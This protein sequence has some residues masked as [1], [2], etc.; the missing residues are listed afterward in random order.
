MQDIQAPQDAQDTVATTDDAT[1]HATAPG[2]IAL[3]AVA[4]AALTACGGGGDAA[5]IAA[6]VVM[7]LGGAVTAAGFMLEDFEISVGRASEVRIAT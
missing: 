6:S 3:A 2:L 4:S 1:S 5:A 7:P